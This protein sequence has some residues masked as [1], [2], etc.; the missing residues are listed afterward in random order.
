MPSDL[1]LPTR[2]ALHCR[3]VPRRRWSVPPGRPYPSKL[4]HFGDLQLLYL[5]QVEYPLWTYRCGLPRRTVIVCQLYPHFRE[6]KIPFWFSPHLNLGSYLFGTY[7][8]SY[9]SARNSGRR[10]E[11]YWA[12]QLE[13]RLG[14]ANKNI[15]WIDWNFYIQL[16]SLPYYNITLHDI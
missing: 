3:V 8:P 4:I 14:L 13:K 9:D 5:D 16:F 12:N 6:R 2:L 15:G 11:Y 7:L 10:S 1:I